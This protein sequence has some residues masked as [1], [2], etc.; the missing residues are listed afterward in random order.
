MLMTKGQIMKLV[1]TTEE[2]RNIDSA[3]PM[4]CWDKIDTSVHVMNYNPPFSM[5]KL[6]NIITEACS[7]GVNLKQYEDTRAN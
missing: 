5:G 3:I 7:R 1:Y 6:E 2:L 4:G